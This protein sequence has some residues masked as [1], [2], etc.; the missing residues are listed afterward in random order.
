MQDE[1][2]KTGVINVKFGHF[3]KRE[4]EKINDEY[5]QDYPDE[6][7]EYNDLICIPIQEVKDCVLKK[8]WN[9]YIIPKN[10]KETLDRWR[11]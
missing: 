3:K 5:Q 8:Y 2:L 1:E 10:E 11:E 9:E 7:K 4:Q 6:E